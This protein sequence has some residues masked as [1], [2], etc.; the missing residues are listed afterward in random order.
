MVKQPFMLSALW[1]GYIPGIPILV[2]TSDISPSCLARLRDHLIILSHGVILCFR[3][4]WCLLINNSLYIN[5]MLKRFIFLE[6]WPRTLDFNNL[7]HY[8]IV[9]NDKTCKTVVR[10]VFPGCPW[11]RKRE[12]V[13]KTLLIEKL[14]SWKTLVQNLK[15]G[16]DC[17][18]GQASFFLLMPVL[19]ME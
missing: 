18:Y 4:K 5:V 11:G 7:L 8:R 1:E 9:T 14:I 19:S 2:Y 17:K 15:F 10:T 16:A 6:K 13:R 12:N 3:K